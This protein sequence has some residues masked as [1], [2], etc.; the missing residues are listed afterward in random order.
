MLLHDRVARWEDANMAEQGHVETEI[1]RILKETIEGDLDYL[2][3]QFGDGEIF[4]PVE[5][6]RLLHRVAS[7]HRRCLI[8]IAREID[9]LAARPG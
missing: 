3:A 7:A 9:D 1:D 4:S 2:E 8:L 6:V 5:Q